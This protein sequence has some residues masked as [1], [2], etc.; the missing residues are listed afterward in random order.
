MVIV[1]VIKGLRS[2]GAQARSTAQWRISDREQCHRAIAAAAAARRGA[3]RGEGRDVKSTV[4]LIGHPDALQAIED[5]WVTEAVR[6][7]CKLAAP[8]SCSEVLGATTGCQDELFES[9]LRLLRDLHGN[10]AQVDDPAVELTLGRACADVARVIHLLR[11]G[12]DG[13]SEGLLEEYDA[14]LGSFVDHT[15]GGDMPQHA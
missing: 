7:T 13:V 15:L 9:R 2:K 1:G 12:G 5:G 10:L 4:R 3:T 11:A 8:N 14:A 6:H